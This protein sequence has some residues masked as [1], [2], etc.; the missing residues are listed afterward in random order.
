MDETPAYALRL[1]EPERSRYRQ[2][3]SRARD[4][5]GEQWR[6]YGIVPGA[7]V[8]DI[9][10]GPGAVLVQLAELVAP[11]GHVVGVEPDPAAR[12]AAIEEIAATGVANATVVEGVGTA[13]T[14]EPATFDV[15][16]IRHVLF[17]VG[18]QVAAVLSHA[19]SLLRPGGHLYVVDTDSTAVRLSVDD[20]D[21]IEQMDRYRA[22]QR[23]RGNNVDIGPRL[24][25]LL[26]A[27]RLEVVEQRGYVS[28]IPAQLLIYGGPA[29]AARG[30]MM[31]AGLITDDD[32][33]RYDDAAA[34]V[35]STPAAVVFTP[36]YA[37]VGRRA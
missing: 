30:E 36:F 34:R 9:G 11:G 6:Q 22:F 35:A 24:G 21:W 4:A 20:A 8:A 25:P 32:S 16:M 23:G 5:E 31:A 26:A 15:V 1:S 27:A 3:A 19:A 7:A 37:A 29:V 33:R 2:M 13:T 14:L 18:G 12:A 10:C 28:T 17:H